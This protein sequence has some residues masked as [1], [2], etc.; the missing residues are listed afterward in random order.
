MGPLELSGRSCS[1]GNRYR[2]LTQLPFPARHMEVFAANGGKGR[3]LPSR[4]WRQ[5]MSTKTR[6]HAKRGS[7]YQPR[8]LRILRSS[9]ENE[10]HLCS[11]GCRPPSTIQPTTSMS[12]SETM[13]DPNCPASACRKTPLLALFDYHRHIIKSSLA[14]LFESKF[15]RG[16]PEL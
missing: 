16:N 3:N 10:A 14:P 12:S 7:R 9:I 1:R 15:V 11:K 4:S 5:R 8:L 2:L 13:D 6:R